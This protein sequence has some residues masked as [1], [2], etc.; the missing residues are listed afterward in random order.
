MLIH[1][2][3]RTYKWRKYS[4]KIKLRINELAGSQLHIVFRMIFFTY[5]C[6]IAHIAHSTVVDVM[7]IHDQVY[8]NDVTSRVHCMK[9]TVNW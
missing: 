1:L 3:D 6:K 7:F 8:F 4:F 9:L 5:V 2:R